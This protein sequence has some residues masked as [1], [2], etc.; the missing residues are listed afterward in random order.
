MINQ[1]KEILARLDELVEA[2][3]SGRYSD[4]YV[5]DLEDAVVRQTEEITN[6]ERQ[7]KQLAEQRD[8]VMEHL[9]SE[10]APTAKEPGSICKWKPWPSNGAR[11]NTAC[12]MSGT[13][14]FEGEKE[15][16]RCGRRVAVRVG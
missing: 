13:V 4:V 7:N 11:H 14:L 8:S 6:L 3:S 1:N 15:C 12:G 10:S 16:P 2:F 5:K 9:F